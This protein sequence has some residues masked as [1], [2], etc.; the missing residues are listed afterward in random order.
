[1]NFMKTVLPFFV[2]ASGMVSNAFAQTDTLFIKANQQIICDHLKENGDQYNFNYLTADNQIAKGSIFKWLVDSVRYAKPLTRS[3]KKKTKVTP[4]EA[5]VAQDSISTPKV[6]NWQYTVT[7]GINLGNVLEFNNPSGTDRKNFTLNTSLDLGLN[8]R[9]EG[10]KFAMTN[11]LHYILG[12]QKEGLTKNGHIQSYQDNL[13]TLHDFSKGIGAGN[14]MNFNLILKTTSSLFTV[15]D[16]NYLRDYNNLGRTKSFASPYDII[17]SPGLKYQ[18]NQYLR[19]SVS[20]YSF[21]LYGIRNSG[22]ADKGLYI[23]E[24]D[25][26]G[27]YKRFLFNRLGAEANFWFDKK[28]KQWLDMQ[29]RLS[30]SSDYF[31][32]FGKNGLMDGFFITKIKIIKDIY[33]THRATIKS[34]LAINFLHPY[35]NQVILISYSKTF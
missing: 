13:I 18:P 4:K 12:F 6:K 9:K 26:N 23:T 14:K 31:G 20:P 27:K 25:A 3:I 10:S 2:L 16:G 33:L 29:Y 30:F 28:V 11:E 7:F 35:Y 17:V 19:I 5:P 1:M 8:Y 22:I 21:Q 15:Y 24:Q 34:N 32:N